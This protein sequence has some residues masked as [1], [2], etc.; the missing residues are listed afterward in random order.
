MTLLPWGILQLGHVPQ[1]TNPRFLL[2]NICV[3]KSYGQHN[4]GKGEIGG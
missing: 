2:A 3:S 1:E 4:D